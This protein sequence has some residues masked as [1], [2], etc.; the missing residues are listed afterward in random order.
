MAFD[1]DVFLLEEDEEEIIPQQPAQ[2]LPQSTGFD[3]DAFLAEE[4]EPEFAQPAPA[5][6]SAY[7]YDPSG[8]RRKKPVVAEPK[9]EEQGILRQVADIPLGIA[10]GGVTGI[11]MMTDILGADNAVSKSL[12]GVEG[13]MADLMSAQAKE[14]QQEISRIMKDAEDK[15]F[16]EQ[17]KAGIKAFS[18]A[19]VDIMSQALGTMAP[20][21]ATGLAGSAAKIGALGI[22]GIQAGVGAGM[23]A[24]MIKGEIYNEVKNELVNSGIAEDAA[25]KAAVDAQSYGGK[26]LDQI[27]LGAGLGA[28]ST[29]GAEGIITRILTKQGTAPAAG[30]VSRVLKGGLTEAAPEAAQAAQEQLA[31][32]VALQREGFDVDPSRGV[33]AAATMEAVAAAPLGGIAGAVERPAPIKTLA[34]ENLE[35]T[36]EIARKV[37]ENGA[38]LTASAIQDQ[39]ATNLRQDEL[40]KQ[41]E[42]QL[43]EEFVAVKEPTA[44]APKPM[45]KDEFKAIYSQVAP[46]ELD[47]AEAGF[48]QQAVTDATEEGRISAQN[49][50]EAIKEVKATV[51]P[52]AP[53][54]EPTITPAVTPAVPT[55]QP[56]TPDATQ[57]IIQPEGVRQEPQDGTQVRQ[58]EEAGVGRS[59]LG[60]AR[61]QEEGQ[62]V[63]TPEPIISEIPPTSELVGAE[64]TQPT[65]R[66]VPEI[67]P[68]VGAEPA[69]IVEQEPVAPAEPAIARPSIISEASR[70][71]NE[72]KQIWDQ[73]APEDRSETFNWTSRAEVELENLIGNLSG[74]QNAAARQNLIEEITGTKPTRQNSAIKNVRQAI[75]GYLQANPLQETAAPTTE[76]AAQP[77][78]KGV[79]QVAGVPPLVKEL[80]TA[81]RE[82]AAQLRARISNVKMGAIEGNVETFTFDLDGQT[83]RG[84]LKGRNKNLVLGT[85]PTADA[86]IA[87][88]VLLDKNATPITPVTTPPVTEAVTPAEA[89]AITPAPVAETPAVAPAAEVAPVEEVEFAELR[90]LMGMRGQAQSKVKGVK[91]SKKDEARYNELLPKYRSRLFETITPEADPVVWKDIQ[92]NDIKVSQ[93]GTFYTVENGRVR[94]GPAFQS[95]GFV[96]DVSPQPVSAAVV[97]SNNVPLPEGYTKQG[98]LY[99]YQPA[100]SETITPAAEPAGIS[101]GSKVKYGTLIRPY[102]VEEVIPQT[103]REIEE[104]DQ[105]YRIRSEQPDKN[106]KYDIANVEKKDIKPILGKGKGKGAMKTAAAAIDTTPENILTTP[107][108]QQY[109]FNEVFDVAYDMFG[110]EIP[111]GFTIVNDSTDKDFEF[112]AA[113]IPESGEIIVNLAYLNKNDDIRDTI[114]HELGHYIFG[115]PEFR[116][117]FDQFIASLSPEARA[118]LDAYVETAYNKETGEI[119]LEEKMVRAFVDQF[120]NEE[121]APAWRSMLDAIKRF[122]NKL[123]FKFNIS[124]RDAISVFTAALDRYKAGEAISRE[125]GARKII[126]DLT[127]MDAEYLA[128]VDEA[129][130]TGDFT[131]VQRMVDEAAKKAGYAIDSYHGTNGDLFT[132]FSTEQG[133]DKTFAESARLGIFSTNNPDVAQTYAENIGVGGTFALGLGQGPLVEARDRAIATPEFKALSQAKDAAEKEYSAT[134]KRIYDKYLEVEKAQLQSAR[135]AF[136]SMLQNKTEAEIDQF[137]EEVAAKGAIREFSADEAVN[138]EPELIAA[139]D[140]INEASK[141]INEYIYPF[142]LEALPNVRVMQLKLQIKNPKVYDAE[143]QTP[144]DFSLSDKIQ[145]AKDLGHDGVIFENIIDPQLPAT[146]YVVF[147][148]QQIKSAD[149]VTY[150]DAGDVIPL[151]QRFRPTSPDIRRMAAEPAPKRRKEQ[152]G[153]AE[154]E[155]TRYITTPKG[156][157]SMNTDVL[158]EKFFDGTSVSP[159][160]TTQAWGYISRLL[161]IKSGNANELAGEI[162]DTVIAELEERRDAAIA[163]GEDVDPDE[164]LEER[165]GAA[166]FSVELMNYAG[167]LAEQGDQRMLK[168]M[169][170]NVNSMPVDKYA[171]GISD[172][173]IGL[174]T[175][176]EY[177]VSGFGAYN[178]DQKGKVERTAAVMFGTNKPNEDQ[179]NTVKDALDKS[180]K[181]ELGNPEEVAGDIENVEKRTGRSVVKKIEEKIKAS[182]APKKEELLISFQNLN[183]DR[184]FAGIN[185]VYKPQ[186][187]DPAKNIQNLIIGKLVDYRKTLI[188]QGADGLESTFWQTM[189]NKERKPGPLGEID[190]AQNNELANIVQK[191][192]IDLG[193]KGEPPNTKMTDIEKV[194]SILNKQLLGEKKKIAAD[195]RVV[196]EIERRRST[197]LE[198]AS[199]ADAVN[200]KYDA[201]LNAWNEAMSRQTNMPISDNMLQRLIN[202]ELKEQGS[203]VTELINEPYEDVLSQ[204]KKGIVDSIIRRVY[205]VSKEAETGIE[206]SEDYDNLSR[207]LKQTLENMLKMQAEKRDA[208]VARTL[209]RGLGDLPALPEVQKNKAQTIVQQDL[210]Q[211]PDM[212]RR[213]PWQNMLVGK[214]TQAGVAPEQAENIANLV[215]RQHEINDANRKI[216][217]MKT[218]AEKGSLAVIID[219]IKNTSLEKQQSPEWKQEVIK[220]YLRD[221]GLSS[222]AAETAAKLYDSI[223]SE[224]LATAKQKAFE[225]TLAKAAPWKNY[226]SRNGKLAKDALKKIKE[227]IRAGVLDPEKNAE[228]IIA[229]LNGWTGFTKEQ[230]QRIVQID[231]I[232]NDPNKDDVTK[233]E[234]MDELNRII[235]KAKLP[236]S[237]REAIGPYYV[238]QALGGIPTATV[239]VASPI[240]FSIRN[241]MVDISKYAATDPAKIPIAFESFLDSMRSWYNQTAYAYKNQIYL[242]DVVEY[243]N[244][245]NVLRELFDKGKQQ[246]AEGKYAEG[247]KNMAIGMMQITGRVLSALD[248]GAISMLENQNIT[249]YAMAALENAKDKV[250]KNKIREFAN[251]TLDLKR[252]VITENIAAGMDKNRAVVLADLA[253]KSEIRA[254]LSEFGVSYKDVLDSAVNDALQSVGR[255]KV[256]TIEGVKKV[257]QDISDS[258][259]LSYPPIKFLEWIASSAGQG[260][261]AMQ[262]FSKMVYGFALIPARTFSTAAWFSPYGFLRLA[263]DKYNKN[264]GQESPYA[265]S[266]Q[267]EAQFKQR[268]TDSIAGSIVML[269]LFAMRSGSSDDE[270]D[271]L[272]K[273]VITG[274]GP[275]ATTDKQYYDTWIKNHKPYSIELHFG[276]SKATINI[277]RGGEALFF[278][279]MLAGALDDWEIKKKQNLTKKEPSDLNIATELLGSAFF[280]L[281]QRGPYAAFTEPLFDASKQGRVTENLV[282]QLGYFGKTFIPVLGTSITRNISDFINDP[283][284]RSSIEG[285]L[286]ANTPIVGPWIGTKALNALGQPIRADDFSDKLFKLGVPVVFSFPKNT[287][288]NALNEIIL[289]QGSGPTIPTRSNAQ[290]RFGDVLTDKEFE[291][292]VREYGR[293]MSDKMFKSRTKLANL[294]PADY[295]DELEK[296]ARGYS[297][298][299]IKIKGASDSAVLAVKRMRQ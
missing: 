118:E 135:G 226:A 120:I 12:A 2:T 42:A 6:Q 67:S 142:L 169:I 247:L 95:E 214:L 93:K 243:L 186:K 232:L 29:L 202:S 105:F 215:W 278:P 84:E 73:T 193:M 204:K 41:L 195:K 233:R 1:P 283:V 20:V 76:A 203:N 92:G 98:D 59:L 27:L 242:N 106:G 8:F 289:K 281:A 152:V 218:A 258:G 23:G 155:E 37:A 121:Q 229:A 270:D 181:T 173:A 97:E 104:G 81:G 227:A 143:G 69:A 11:K 62:V 230:Y 163:A 254:A 269:A 224:R 288:E 53:T 291:A 35:Q 206:I 60:A 31:K 223:I 90:N 50:L 274:N 180:E 208:A 196:E 43:E 68:I 108:D 54:V 82:S 205:G 72:R 18:I 158:R 271:K 64:P 207:Y 128:A 94:T 58:T 171:G 3:P 48:T 131:E 61:G 15:G 107:P 201:I 86:A 114:T 251:M 109:T 174:R 284:D 209:Q 295:D 32:N 71:A 188:K 85:N 296:Y 262:I 125:G 197:E 132:I 287:P 113:Y 222:Q 111:E 194:A 112:K 272:F 210:R 293:V 149:P 70:I 279:I 30:V 285:A 127:A 146:H 117:A 153:G 21:L 299:G 9:P 115:D 159:E 213:E 147:E 56:P 257:Q 13:Y 99:V 47:A 134:S 199:D 77:A 246:W 26:N 14:D 130:R 101:V 177:D 34:E 65:I 168:F 138:K 183:Q 79:T 52:P 25:E 276:D 185:I 10:R 266:L 83:Y 103:A 4:E 5:A 200:A 239:N 191:T 265:M 263:I 290:K 235:S 172:L 133:G 36:N 164:N 255:N 170:R 157:L 221:A 45:S 110:G 259:F 187:I 44:A 129:K 24:G 267:T 234:A 140:K 264:K 249:R 245:Q 160:K 154:R 151:S 19:P 122:L 145:E 275:N 141:A 212:G 260:G 49:A 241:L 240:G 57:E 182:T 22:R 292:Y 198:G 176:L 244:G 38:P 220:E 55:A 237:A 225:D 179:F 75:R 166:M 144:A 190:Q 161:D 91:F 123:G 184:K 217:E 231:T 280:A 189:S 192:L 252:R 297:I 162:N 236:V 148:P 150:D 119:R 17:V 286:Y 248:Q 102:I 178:A 298:D 261:P 28:A 277:G 39:A 88:R 256:I 87:T 228:S 100:I 96:G 80:A 137:I 33:V 268:L 238:G 216:K 250:P 139:Q 253:V 211:Q 66:E 165:I 89:P 78:P 51:T 175:R 16:G 136:R 273:I 46:E 294:K 7:Q 282:G 74:N 219:R 124:D 63:P 167:K 156:I 126:D 116:A 40:A